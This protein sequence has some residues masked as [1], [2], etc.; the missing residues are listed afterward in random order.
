MNLHQLL[1]YLEPEKAHSLAKQ[2]LKILGALPKISPI[3][4]P[5]LE[6]QILGL[7]LKNPIGLAAG[8]DKDAMMLAGLDYLGFGVLEV[9]TLTPKPQSGNPKPRVWRFVKEQSLQNAMGFN[10]QGIQK[11]VLRLENLPPLSS[12]VGINL[13]KNKN[14]PLNQAL[15]DYENALQMS[16][17]VGDYYVF[18]LSSPNTPN[19]RDLQNESFVDELFAMARA[20]THKPLFLKISP[21]APIDTLLLICDTAIDHGASGIIATNTTTDYSVLPHAQPTGGISGKAL[22]NKAVAV[23]EQIAWVFFK[24]AILVAVGGI[25]N[26]TQAYARIKMGASFVQIFTAFI[27][28]GPFICR[29]INQDIVELLQQD[30]LKS[31]HEAVG[32]NL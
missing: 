23:F 22:E 8:F 11:A 32:V 27:Y 18:N 24:K 17:G 12:V 9:G 28:Q 3:A 20:K 19:L 4:H 10:N 25:S 26:A 13:G 29:Q 16:L 21:D 30:G 14:T 5:M 2:A 6:Q 1:F 7:S 31:V 15:K